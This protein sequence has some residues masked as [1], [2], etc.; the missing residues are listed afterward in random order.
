MDRY[1]SRRIFLLTFPYICST[2]VRK[3]E[4]V[5]KL[6]QFGLVVWTVASQQVGPNLS[7]PT[8][9]TNLL[10]PFV[11]EDTCTRLNKEKEKK[12]FILKSLSFWVVWCKRIYPCHARTH[13][14]CCDLNQQWHSISS[15]HLQPRTGSQPDNYRGA[16]RAK[17]EELF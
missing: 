14:Q 4:F 8:E 15:S 13:A 5:S 9:N 7:S 6:M 12:N 1:S 11:V 16:R 2:S 3:Y 10:L 17:E